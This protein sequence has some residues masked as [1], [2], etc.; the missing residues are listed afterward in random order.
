MT[1]ESCTLVLSGELGEAEVSLR[2]GSCC[3]YGMA[4]LVRG[5]GRLCLKLTP[6]RPVRAEKIKLVLSEDL[7]S[8]E[9]VFLNGWQSWTDSRETPPDGRMRGLRRA[10][11]FLVRRFSLAGYG[12]Y[13]F[14]DYPDRPGELHGWSYGYT[15][16][17]D[18][19]RLFASLSEDGG[20]TRFR[21]DLAAGTVAAEK[22]VSGRV[23][24][25]GETAV[26]LDLFLAEG[27]EDAVFGRWFAALGLRAPSAPPVSGYTSWYRHY[28]KIS[29]S[30]L[31]A[32][33][34]GVKDS[35]FGFQVFQI[36]DGWESAV[37]DWEP[38][39]GKFPRGL[40]PL[41][42]EIAGAGMTPGLWLA[43][44]VAE[45]KSRVFA[46][47]PD[48][49]LR[50]EDGEFLS[51]GGN[52]GG[53]RVL[54]LDVPEAREHIRAVLRR[55]AE[56]WGFPFLKLDF[57]Y[58]ACL[59]PKKGVTR[60]EAMGRAMEFLRACA[61]DA[62]ILACGVPLFSAFGRADYCRVGC[63]AGLS[64]DDKPWMRLLHRERVSTKN[65]LQNSVFRRQLSGRAFISDPDVF[66]LRAEGNSLSPERRAALGEVNA[67]C[68]GV[69]FTS[70]DSA[71][72]GAEQ[73]RELEKMQ[74]LRGARVL[75]AREDG[76]VLELR[77]ACGGAEN[78]LRVKL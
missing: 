53:I 68:G 55:A 13:S 28:Q 46:E 34:R 6:S 74:G 8:A 29:E 58:A 56:D 72:Y 4:A 77:Y 30:A 20:F 78:T 69:L 71:E 38:D 61:G 16:R 60:G 42:G 7:A 44:F 62:R 57:L 51:A 32:D 25:P 39:A 40:G 49:F 70:D 15:R 24:A 3:K 26:L 14:T 31:L 33:L 75:G 10:P 5:D 43:P 76:K 27:A 9:A 1:P 22:E 18:D 23:Y 63:D 48:W 37:G 36:D 19:F 35:P 17:G 41:R 73:K 50:G 11:G 64:W 21:T 47:H 2:G 45:K 67:L 65:S 12:D 54:D 52:W 66:I 59:A